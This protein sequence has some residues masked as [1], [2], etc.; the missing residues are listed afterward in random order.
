MSLSP[1]L[2]GVSNR[3]YHFGCY[4]WQTV[5]AGVE[6]SHGV[7]WAIGDGVD[8]SLNGGEEATGGRSCY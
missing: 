3:G 4:W 5:W 1:F 2:G 8:G 6:S 7:K